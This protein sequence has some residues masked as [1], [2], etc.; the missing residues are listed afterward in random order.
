MLMLN[1]NICP[2]L[3]TSQL[4]LLAPPVPV[5]FSEWETMLPLA[6]TVCSV[7][8]PRAILPLFLMIPDMLLVPLQYLRVDKSIAPLL[9]MSRPSPSLLTIFD[10]VCVNPEIH[11]LIIPP[12]PTVKAMSKTVAISGDNPF[13]FLSRAICR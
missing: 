7:M 6:K 8:L 2:A 5:S 9:Q 3:N 10:E 4:P 11:T 13:I 12:T 1:E